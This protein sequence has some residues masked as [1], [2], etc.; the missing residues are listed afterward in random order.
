MK[1]IQQANAR[2]Y[3]SDYDGS[4]ATTIKLCID[5]M[6]FFHYVLYNHN[7]NATPL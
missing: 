3:C 7:G 2:L 1:E 6:Y 5:G 4:I